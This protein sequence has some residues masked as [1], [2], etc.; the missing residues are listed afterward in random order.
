MDYVRAGLI[1]SLLM[2]QGVFAMPWFHEIRREAITR[3]EAKQELQQWRDVVATLGYDLPQ[4]E[5]NAELIHI[6]SMLAAPQLWLKRTLRPIMTATGTGQG[7]GLFAAPD[8]YPHRLI[9]EAK[10]P[11]EK[12]FELIYQRHDPEHDWWD[13]RFRY[14]RLRGIYDGATSRPGAVYT[15]FCQWVATA[16][17]KEFSEYEVV[18]VGFIRT[19]S[20]VPGAERNTRNPRRLLRTFKRDQVLP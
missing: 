16:A 17:L 20:V 1:F 2:V 12:H 6:S 19:H 4:D 10:R 15:N 3:P 18:R 8:T 14:R 5:F 9:V 13:E 7:W 11:S